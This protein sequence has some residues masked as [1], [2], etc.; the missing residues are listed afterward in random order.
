MLQCIS[1]YELFTVLHVQNKRKQKQKVLLSLPLYKH[2]VQVVAS[3]AS[4]KGQAQHY[5]SAPETQPF[6]RYKAA[7]VYFKVSVECRCIHS[8]VL[9]LG[10]S[11]NSFM[12]C[13]SPGLAFAPGKCAGDP[14]ATHPACRV[15]NQQHCHQTAPK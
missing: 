6:S 8:S 7:L 3:C 2:C 4:R 10:V 12:P 13:V 11:G 5:T 1:A 14:S 15:P 9:C